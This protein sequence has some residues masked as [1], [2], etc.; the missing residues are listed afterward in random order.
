LLINAHVSKVIYGRTYIDPR[1]VL[2]GV[3][4]QDEYLSNAGIEVMH[5]PLTQGSF[6]YKDDKLYIKL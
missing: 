2:F 3:E 6:Y 4:S 1:C 5:L